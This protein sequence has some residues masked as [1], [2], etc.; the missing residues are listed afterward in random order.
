MPESGSLNLSGL[1]IALMV[2]GAAVGAALLVLSLLFPRLQRHDRGDGQAA[3]LPPGDRPLRL[4]PGSR[5]EMPPIVIKETRE[6]ASLTPARRAAYWRGNLRLIAVL[7]LAWFGCSY[8][9]ALLAPWLN[10]V[11]IFT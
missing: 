9:P 2:W 10:Q 4:Q 7:L 8:L 6:V 3:A 11:G 5:A 1:L